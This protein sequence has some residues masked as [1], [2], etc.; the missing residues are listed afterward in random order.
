[1]LQ[2]ILQQAES[3]LPQDASESPAEGARSV[4]TEYIQQSETSSS[5]ADNTHLINQRPS[6]RVR[7]DYEQHTAER[8]AQYSGACVISSGGLGQERTG[9]HA[10]LPDETNVPM[11]S[12]A[13]LPGACSTV[14][15]KPEYFAWP[16]ALHLPFVFPHD[17]CTSIVKNNGLASVELSMKDP[18]NCY[19]T[20][21]I[22]PT[23]VQL[24]AGDL[25][26][27]RIRFISQR[28]HIY[29]ENGATVHGNGLLELR[30]AKTEKI[31]MILGFAVGKA[32]RE[33]P[34]RVEEHLSGQSLSS[35]VSFTIG[36][37]AEDSG[38]LTIM[39][40]AEQSLEICHRLSGLV[41]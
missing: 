2:N 37:K 14:V 23:S 25:F 28:R 3:T 1:M 33:S 32:F 40:N 34:H 15:K 21:E 41:Q 29:F 39:L 17:I 22:L 27:V 30:G 20:L 19:M 5:S 12:T 9:L 18:T 38:R 35:A 6:K 8:K 13:S 36:E 10:P 4:D 26:G 11:L 7:A 31:D 16:R 24:M